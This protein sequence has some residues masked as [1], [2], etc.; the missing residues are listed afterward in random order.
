V[1]RRRFVAYWLIHEPGKD[2]GF[3]T[4]P[5]EAAEDVNEAVQVWRENLT[6]QMAVLFDG[7]PVE[8]RLITKPFSDE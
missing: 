1:T 4:L 6:P 5:L 7:M 8:A 2:H 3:A